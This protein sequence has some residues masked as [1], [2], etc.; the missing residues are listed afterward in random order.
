MVDIRFDTYYRYEAITGFLHAWA[1]EY[2]GLCRVVSLGKSY[3]GRDIWL[4][5]VTNFASGPDNEK[6]AFWV[7]AN[8]HATEVSPSSAALHL[9][10]TLLNGYGQGEK[11]TYALDSR[12]FYVVPRLNPDGAELALADTPRFIRSSTRPYPR[13]DELDGFVQ[14][15]IDRDGRIL[16]MRIKDPHGAWKVHPDEPRLLIPRAGDDL[17]GGDY[18]R[19]L[20]EGRIRNYDGAI[21]KMAPPVEG[22]DL[23]RNFPVFWSPDQYGSGPYPA[24]EPEVRP[25][26]QFITDHPNICG[27]ISFHTFSG[28]HL[29]PPTKEPEDKMNTQDLFT[30]KRIGAKATELTG[31]PAISIYHD[32]KYDPKDYIKGTFDDWMYEFR[33]V[34]AWTTEIWSVQQQAGI[35]DYKFI[36][37]SREHP[38]EHDVQILKWFDDEVDGE[39][40][41]NWYEYD[42][43][44][45]G[46]V[47]LGGWHTFITWR[48]PPYRK[49]EKEIA[50]LTEFAIYH[51]LISPRL[52]L[53]QVETESNGDTHRIRLVLHNTGWL[54]TNITEQALKMKVVRQLEVDI[55]LPEGARLL[56]GEKK[57]M[58]G[59]LKG[60]DHKGSTTIWNADSTD[61]RVKVEW[62]VQGPAGSV[63]TITAT[64]ER[65]GMV[66]AEVTLG[67]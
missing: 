62:V 31:Y 53:Y 51:C 19:L 57:T 12:V 34:Y 14:E 5:T 38:A 61:E 22:L 52:E 29:R 24:S 10:H 3:E 48:N 59:Q 26:V 47:E 60:R 9:I 50:P 67:A 43:P 33:G 65:A 6:P 56:V 35:K 41:I 1:E 45:L 7:D 49:L 18:Y 32:F 58:L 17:P 63:V 4:M 54:P 66:R 36:D 8:I 23:N 15:D 64:H 27:A 20:P 21:I 16:L 13:T 11:I 44:Q 28:V 2:P 40:Y 46:K 42:H 55:E 37:W 30:Y 39:S 25:A